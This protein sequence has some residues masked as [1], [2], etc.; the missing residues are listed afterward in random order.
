[1]GGSMAGGQI[2]WAAHLGGFL[3]GFGLLK[4]KYFN[5]I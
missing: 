3:A 5:I 2:A 1:V 4:L